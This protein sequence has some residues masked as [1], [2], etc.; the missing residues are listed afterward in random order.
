MVFESTLVEILAIETQERYIKT[1][2]AYNRKKSYFR[3]LFLTI[4]T[5]L[6]ILLALMFGIASLY[7]DLNKHI[8]IWQHN[9]ILISKSKRKPTYLV[10]T[11]FLIVNKKVINELYQQILKKHNNSFIHHFTQHQCSSKLQHIIKLHQYQ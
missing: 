6:K 4:I 9:N 8:W 3:N 1:I 7:K 5:L 10:G 2:Q 11:L